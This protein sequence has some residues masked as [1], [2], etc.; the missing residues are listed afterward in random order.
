MYGVMGLGGRF[1]KWTLLGA[2]ATRAASRA[3]MDMGRGMALAI[4]LLRVGA[5]QNARFCDKLVVHVFMR[6]G[7]VPELLPLTVAP[8]SCH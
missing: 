5:D 6:C 3:D 7:V 1:S 4:T 2:M 8:M